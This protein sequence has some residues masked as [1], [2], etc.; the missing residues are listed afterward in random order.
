MG[1]Y[2]LFG[3]VASFAAARLI[4]GHELTDVSTGLWGYNSVLVAIALGAVVQGL[5]GW[6]RRVPLVVV[7]VALSLAFQHVLVETAIPVF[8]WPFLLGMW[9]TLLLVAGARRAA[10]RG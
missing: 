1:L 3:A 7:G 8:T 2:G 5:G 6:R 4:V 9:A 10:G